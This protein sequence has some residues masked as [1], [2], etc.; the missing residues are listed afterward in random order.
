MSNLTNIITADD[1]RSAFKYESNLRGYD[2]SDCDSE[3]VVDGC[4]VTF[5]GCTVWMIAESE[6]KGRLSTADCDTFI[7]KGV[8]WFTMP[9]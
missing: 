7:F 2:L 1:R 9:A 6:A 4:L 3:I 8:T 5:D